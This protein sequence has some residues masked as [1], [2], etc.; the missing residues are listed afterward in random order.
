MEGEAR[1]SRTIY[2]SPEEIIPYV[3]KEVSL[4]F[5]KNSNVDNEIDRLSN[6]HGSPSRVYRSPERPGIPQAVIATWGAIELR[7]LGPADLALLV[8]NK[9]PAVGVMVDFLDDFPRSAQTA[10]EAALDV[11]INRQAF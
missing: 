8:Q 9:G 11:G 5:F 4:G 7:P 2:H 1:I 10:G 3:N 6:R